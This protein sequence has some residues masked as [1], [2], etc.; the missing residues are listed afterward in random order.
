MEVDWEATPFTWHT[1]S[2]QSQR[3]D[4]EMWTGKPGGPYS[5]PAARCTDHRPWAHSSA[6]GCSPEM[7]PVQLHSSWVTL[8]CRK[9]ARRDSY[10]S[11][12]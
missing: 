7:E 2:P 12:L 4:W 11:L 3:V 9:C 8:A 5:D 10:S 6:L 1:Q